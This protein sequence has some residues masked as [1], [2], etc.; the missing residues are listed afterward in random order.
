[1]YVFAKFCPIDWE[2]MCIYKHAYTL[3]NGHTMEFVSLHLNYLLS[4]GVFY[5]TY[6]I[7]PHILKQEVNLFS[8]D[9]QFLIK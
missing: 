8:T 4:F 9:M 6:Y 1:M 3:Y 7:R 2:N 5:L